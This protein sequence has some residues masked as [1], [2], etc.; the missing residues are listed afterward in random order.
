M[1]SQ[2]SAISEQKQK[3]E[4][5]S[6]EITLIST[7]FPYRDV[8]LKIFSYC[9][10]ESILLGVQLLNKDMQSVVLNQ[11]E[12]I[13]QENL[14]RLEEREKIKYKNKAFE[15]VEKGSE[16][17]SQI[18]LRVL[19]QQVT[20]RKQKRLKEIIF[21]SGKD[22]LEI[23]KICQK[24]AGQSNILAGFV[25]LNFVRLSNVQSLEKLDIDSFEFMYDIDPFFYMK[26]RAEYPIGLLFICCFKSNQ[27]KNVKTKSFTQ[28]KWK[29]VQEKISS[30]TLQT[31]SRFLREFYKISKSAALSVSLIHYYQMPYKILDGQY[32]TA[33]EYFQQI[34]SG[35]V[36][37]DENIQKFLQSQMYHFL[38]EYYEKFKLIVS[39]KKTISYS[40][41]N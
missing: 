3:I 17:R 19:K 25:V 6:S 36:P 37:T 13:W 27:V 35:T 20:Y 30:A 5:I 11:S 12:I 7:P 2:E 26:C 15:K 8:T 34:N 14:D 1:E 18:M 31:I 29:Q 33:H 32:L 38:T 22:R 21:N 39:S 28:T 41:T 24:Y 23:L 16:L 40:T 9:S 10:L 4:S